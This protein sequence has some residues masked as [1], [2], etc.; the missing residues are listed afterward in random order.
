MHTYEGSINLFSY[1]KCTR[2]NLINKSY[3]VDNYQSEIASRVFQ[4]PFEHST[5]HI[6]TSS[7]NIK[8][9]FLNPIAWSAKALHRS[10]RE[11]FISRIDNVVFASKHLLSLTKDIDIPFDVTK[12]NLLCEYSF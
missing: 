5:E 9:N 4:E 2:I 7:V 12:H 11:I 1:H 6:T 3:D 10:D 8:W